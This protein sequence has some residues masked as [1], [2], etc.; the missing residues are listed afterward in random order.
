MRASSPVLQQESVGGRH[1]R[2]SPHEQHRGIDARR[3]S[4]N[5]DWSPGDADMDVD[6]SVDGVE[7][8]AKAVQRVHGE[9][10]VSACADI[11]TDSAHRDEDAV[12][13]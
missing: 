6:S 5:I 2:C 9:G 3:V 7:N 8:F 12:V 13:G 4:H 11:V 1:V 10:S